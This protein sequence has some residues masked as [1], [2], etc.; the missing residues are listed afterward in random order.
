M[1]AQ[2]QQHKKVARNKHNSNWQGSRHNN[3]EAVNQVFTANKMEI[4][5]KT[6]EALRIIRQ[7]DHVLDKICKCFA[8][9]TD[10]V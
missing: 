6:L 7:A 10:Y 9:S 5:L 4:K 2:K 8:D 1:N 3:V